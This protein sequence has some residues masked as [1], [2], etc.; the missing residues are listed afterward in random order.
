EARVVDA[1][2]QLDLG[3]GV[4]DR[5][6]HQLGGHHPG[7]VD[8]VLGPAHGGEGI[9]HLVASHLHRTGLVRESD[10]ADVTTPSFTHIAEALTHAHDR[11]QLSRPLALALR[12]GP[13]ATFQFRHARAQSFRAYPRPAVVRPAQPAATHSSPASPGWATP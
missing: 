6:G 4:D 8:A 12:I 7:L 11:T 9:G 1:H 13:A 2:G 3:G 10:P 5:V